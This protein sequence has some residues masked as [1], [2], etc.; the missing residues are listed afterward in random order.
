MIK[1]SIVVM[2]NI[3]F[4]IHS[5]GFVVPLLHSYGLIINSVSFSILKDLIS[6][7]FMQGG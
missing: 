1:K 2:N 7:Y 6:T 3:M 4:Y 5:W